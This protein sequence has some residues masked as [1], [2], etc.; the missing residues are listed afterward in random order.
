[1][2]RIELREAEMER[3]CVLREVKER[4]LTQA[5]G[6]QR[7]GLTS[8][9]IRRLL[10]RVEDQGLQGIKS[11]RLGGNRAFSEDYK[12]QVMATIK[13]NYADFGPTFAS[14]KLLECQGLKI[15]RETLRQWMIEASMWNGRP[16]KS[17][18]IHQS[19]ERRPRLGEL[20]QI[21]GSHHDWFEGRAPQCC[22]LVFI[23]DATSK[24][25]ALRFEPSETT[26]GYLRCI[27]DHLKTH[28]RPLAYYS[29][30]HS[31]FKTTRKACID[32]RLADTQVHRALRD[33]QIELICAHSSQAKGR[34]ERVNK[35]LQDRLIKEMRLR[36]ISTIEEANAYLP[37]FL[38]RHNK[39]FGVQATNSADS[40]R[41]LY[42]K[43]EALKRILSV[44][45]IRKLSKNLEFSHNCN[46]YQIQRHGGGY[47]FR[48]AAVTVCEHTDGTVEI[49]YENESLQYKV[50]VHSTSQ[51]LTV[52]T[53]EINPLMDQLALLVASQTVAGALPTGST[54][55]AQLSR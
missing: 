21:D 10:K 49:F 27:E 42:H 46:L 32:G 30:K 48:H 37:S 54:A 39:R 35:T 20:V 5:E 51:P 3:I 6:G 18:R 40:H 29:D 22:L 55:P 4:Q 11:C 8:R 47:R 44:Q 26:L 52:D 28:G 15:N 24:I 2:V 12:T 31:I 34:V 41:P 14:E 19:R 7:L 45:S 9:Q 38:A 50:Q 36:H 25:L 53:K 17:A 16:R 13:G 1:M 23:D 33:L 43:P